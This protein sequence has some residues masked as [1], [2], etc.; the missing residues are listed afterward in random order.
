MDRIQI[1]S[2]EGME[3]RIGCVKN[4]TERRHDCFK[5]YADELELQ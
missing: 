5:V 2:D 3:L 1:L 4:E